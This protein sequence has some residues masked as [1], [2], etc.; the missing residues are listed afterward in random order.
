L[1]LLAACCLL[2]ACL[3]RL[4]LLLLLLHP[5]PAT[6]A[7]FSPSHFALPTAVH[8]SSTIYSIATVSSAVGGSVVSATERPFFP[9]AIMEFVMLVMQSPN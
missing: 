1:L 9:K 6:S 3:L 4:L 7:T 5:P 8:L 2:L